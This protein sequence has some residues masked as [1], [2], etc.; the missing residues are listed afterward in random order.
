LVFLGKPES[1]AAGGDVIGGA[2]GDR[3][4]SPHDGQ[5]RHTNFSVCLIV[6]MSANSLDFQLIYDACVRESIAKHNW[7]TTN[8]K[9]ETL[10]LNMFANTTFS[11]RILSLQEIPPTLVMNLASENYCK[12]A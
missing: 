7:H 10:T 5:S 12:P 8:V 3:T 1:F 11:A 4:P 2:E 6:S 9:T